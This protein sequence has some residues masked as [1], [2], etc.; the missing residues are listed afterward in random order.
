MIIIIMLCVLAAAQ[1][2]FLARHILLVIP[3]QFFAQN[4]ET[5]PGLLDLQYG[6][7]RPMGTFGEPS[8][9]GFI[10]LALLMMFGK[11]RSN[12]KSSSVMIVLIVAAGIMSKS[13]SFLLFFPIA[14][15]LTHKNS[16]SITTQIR[17]AAAIVLLFGVASMTGVFNIATMRL[18]NLASGHADTS[19][20]IRII[21]PVSILGEYLAQHPFGLPPSRVAEALA[22]LARQYG[23]YNSVVMDNA[24]LNLMFCYGLPGLGIFG[25]FVTSSNRAALAFFLFACTQFNGA[26]LTI[27]KYTVICLVG[28]LFAASFD[29][30]V[31]PTAPQ[32]V[33]A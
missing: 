7:Q 17:A 20:L 2:F 22:P 13:L 12:L 5:I 6:G 29:K 19:I 8:Y 14:L 31:R 25:Y 9:F 15:Y 1:S 26:L 33:L 18:G 24:A 23:F 4:A 28:A 30:Q 32:S 21:T 11:L 10:L 16:L 27:D 3:K